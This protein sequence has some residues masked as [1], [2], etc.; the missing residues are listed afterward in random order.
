DDFERSRQK[1]AKQGQAPGFER[2]WQQRVV[3]VGEGLARQDP[4]LVP[5]DAT[6]GRALSAPFVRCLGCPSRA[7]CWPAEARS[8]TLQTGSTPPLRRRPRTFSSYWS[9]AS[10]RS[11]TV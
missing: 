3:G 7:G 8:K 11:R 5:A 4:R 1:L 9:R 2:L 10:M 6:L